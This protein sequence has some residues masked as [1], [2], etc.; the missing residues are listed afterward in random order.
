GCHLTQ[1]AEL[2][3]SAEHLVDL[4][5]DPVKVSINA[6]GRLPAKDPPGTLQRAG[7][8]RVDADSLQCQPQLLVPQG[9]QEGVAWLG[10]HRDRVGGKPNR[11]LPHRRGGIGRGER[12]LPHLSATRELP[13]DR[14]R[15]SKHRL[16]LQPAN[17]ILSFV[18]ALAHCSCSLT[19][20]PVQARRPRWTG[21][22]HHP[23]RPHLFSDALHTTVTGMH[24]GTHNYGSVCWSDRKPTPATLVPPASRVLVVEFDPL[25]GHH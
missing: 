9:T 20:R 22:T 3:V 11:G 24:P 4:G 25:S 10:D 8:H 15:V 21:T 5:A 18:A 2:H 23:G 14:A 6:G 17:V 1:A 12:A 7:V 19:P 16:L 13:G